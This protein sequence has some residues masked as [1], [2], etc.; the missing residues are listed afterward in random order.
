[1]NFN[2]P[3]LFFLVFSASCKLQQTENFVKCVGIFLTLGNLACTHYLH[4]QSK[5]IVKVL[6]KKFLCDQ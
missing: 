6:V 2:M 3:I 5:Q 1:M 4:E